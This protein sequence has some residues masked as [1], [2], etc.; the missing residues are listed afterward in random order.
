MKRMTERERFEAAMARKFPGWDFDLDLDGSYLFS[1]M[2]GAWNG[3]KLAVAAAK[4]DARR[5]GCA[6]CGYVRKA[7]AKR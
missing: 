2:D 4:R 5:T 1:W 6:K 3:W 7:E